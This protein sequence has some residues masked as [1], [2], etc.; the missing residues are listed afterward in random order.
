MSGG[1]NVG[2]EEGCEVEAVKKGV[3][4]KDLADAGDVVPPQG[5]EYNR[6][7]YVAWF[8]SS[9]QI[10][11]SK[12]YEN[13]LKSVLEAQKQEEMSIVD[14]LKPDAALVEKTTENS[15]EY[16]KTLAARR[17]ALLKKSLESSIVEPHTGVRFVFE[18]TQPTGSRTV[19]LGPIT[20][21][22]SNDSN[23]NDSNNLGSQFPQVNPSSVV[24]T[25]KW[26]SAPPAL[27]PT[28][29]PPQE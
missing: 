3:K 28:P 12:V 8:N 20:D 5:Q 2:K 7:Q 23:S 15:C 13:N 22:N 4:G 25:T 24:F 29:H 1:G 19:R 9:S 14:E 16:N 6:N 11:P 27:F 10:D 21:F 26:N 17:R 18:S